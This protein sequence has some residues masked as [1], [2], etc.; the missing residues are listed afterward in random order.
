MS[1]WGTEVIRYQKHILTHIGPEEAMTMKRLMPVY[2]M[3]L[4]PVLPIVQSTPD[5]TYLG[6]K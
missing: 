6:R 1:I 2:P 4:S 5:V 3:I